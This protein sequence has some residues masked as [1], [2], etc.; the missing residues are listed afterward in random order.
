MPQTFDSPE[1]LASAVIERVGRKI[2]LGLPVGLGKAV[3]VANALYERAVADPSLELTIFTALTLEAPRAGSDL[4]RRFLE[5]LVRRLY[6]EW[7]ELAYASA[8]TEERL[9]ENIQVREFYFRPAAYLGNPAAQQSYTSLNYTQVAGALL[10][11]GVNVI[12]QL[13]TWRDDD[14]S[15]LSLGAN[16]EV[17]LDLLPALE[18]R[19]ADGTGVAIV[20]QVNDRMP[21]MF[22]DAELPPQR[23]DFL[24]DA[25]KYTFPM[26]GLP[27]RKVSRRDYA[28]GM[29]VASLVADGGTLQLGIGSLSDAVAHCLI[30]R[31]RSPEVFQAVLARLPGGTASGR[32]PRLPVH[33]GS[34]EKGLYVA[35]E[36]L[37]DA[38]FALFREGIVDR[39]AG[40]GDDACLHAGFFLGSQALYE[41]LHALPESRRRR[42]SM[43]AISF[44]NSLH[45]DEAIK[46]RQRVSASFVNEVMMVTLLGA[47]V[48][49]ALEDG[50]V[51]SGV[52]GQFDFVRMAHALD[53]AHSVLMFGS[54]RMHDGKPRSN[55]VWKY[56][57]ATVPRHFRDVFANE[58]GLAATRGL[59]DQDVIAAL[60]D[61]AD[62][63]FQA[64]LLAAARSAGKI[65]RDHA[66][67]NSAMD[68]T[69]AA[70]A[71]VLDDPAF[72]GHFPDYPL[73]TDL[74][75][76]EQRLAEALTW[77]KHR[78]A[79]SGQRLTTMLG[80]VLDGDSRRHDD[81]LAR[82]RLA[83]PATLRE[84]VSRRLLV[85][86]L[87]RRAP[88]S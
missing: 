10:E 41:G 43:R 58:Y 36:L 9:P 7:P 62:A 14:R 29:H 26:F 60:L 13:V 65:A 45:G 22:G 54:H 28:T 20:G 87:N 38:A 40:A 88:R 27:N 57:H 76:V 23:F 51:V 16:P 50:R 46:R 31:H 44:V 86:A 30:L 34:F 63:R 47:A 66:V 85:H 25:P 4:E 24:L 12:G 73:G 2:V 71:E 48:S 77:L 75:E 84:R 81:A 82:M 78:T 64:N 35:T 72:A 33:A 53:H 42:I 21:Y 56:G 49:D 37:S 15:M 18:R 70:I 52:G 55:I 83:N 74:T 19:R 8:V 17:T 1:P 79:T 80:A 32:R 39:G 11:L 69:P 5:P 68:N 61:I 3:H 6:R 59:C 67:R